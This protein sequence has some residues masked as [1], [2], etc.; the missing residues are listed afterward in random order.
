MLSLITAC[1][2]PSAASRS[3]NVVPR[4]LRIPSVRKYAASANRTST[5]GACDAGTAGRRGS[6]TSWAE[7]SQG[8][9]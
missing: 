1:G 6:L 3:S 9:R 5:T 7:P 2:G 4:L 8:T